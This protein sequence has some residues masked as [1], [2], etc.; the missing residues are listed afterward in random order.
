MQSLPY[1]FKQNTHQ[2]NTNTSL[3]DTAML[4]TGDVCAVYDKER[5][6]CYRSVIH[7]VI[8]DKV[9]FLVYLNFG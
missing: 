8:E 1:Y 7:A 9:R 2:Y 6:A 3:R 5:E 4:S